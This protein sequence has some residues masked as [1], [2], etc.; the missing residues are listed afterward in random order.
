M[1]AEEVL[2]AGVLC[3]G[4]GWFGGEVWGG[5]GEGVH[6]AKGGGSGGRVGELYPGITLPVA[7][8]GKTIWR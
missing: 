1:W 4:D 2:L 6:C 7:A 5:G 3:R 8:L